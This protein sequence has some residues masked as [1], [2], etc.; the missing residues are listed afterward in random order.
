MHILWS[1]NASMER[2]GVGYPAEGGL[3][4]EIGAEGTQVS[5]KNGLRRMS[6]QAISK[7]I[8]AK[9]SLWL[10]DSNKMDR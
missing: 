2:G 8:D 9:G 10:K 7:S 6:G 4:K 1:E 5:E 3:A